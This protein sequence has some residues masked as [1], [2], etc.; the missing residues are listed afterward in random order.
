[1]IPSTM[2]SAEHESGSSGVLFERLRLMLDWYKGMISERTGRLLYVYD[3]ERQVA[4]ADGSPIRDI[5]S[6]W[7]VEL[8]SRFLGSSELLPLAA[9]WLD[10]YTGYLTPRD[11]ALIL[12][13][14]RLGEPSGIAHSAFLMLA[15]LESDAPGREATVAALADG[16]LRQQRE[17]GSYR[18]YFGAEDD[19]GLELYPGEAMLALMQAYAV[20]H[21]ARLVRS[22]ER[23][24][25]GHHDRFP[26]SAIAPD[27]LVFYANWQSQYAA[28]LHAHTQNETIR[29]AV[30]DHVFALHDRIVSARFYDDVERLPRRQATVE[31]ACALE[32]INDAYTI[33]ARDGDDRRVRAYERSLRIAL[34]WLLRAQR[35]DDC[36]FRERGGFGHSLTDRT[37]RIDVTGHVVGGFIKTAQNRIVGPSSAA[38]PSKHGRNPA[39]ES[40]GSGGA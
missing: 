4:I 34:A 12:D 16:I 24:F 10:H 13:R 38:S 1:M 39:G 20:I 23:G 28:L 22:V 27:Y 2:R 7:D 21:D 35:L 30:R 15:L 40:G 19:E 25:R 17:D 5:A 33:A 3:P 8:L 36:F 26:E 32:G 37:Q 9:R 31:V 6:I 29:S 14:E 18:I 11:G